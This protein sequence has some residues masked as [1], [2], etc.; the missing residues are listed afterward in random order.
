MERYGTMSLA[1]ETNAGIIPEPAMTSSWKLAKPK[2]WPMLGGWLVSKEKQIHM[3]A[4]PQ[5][6]KA[7]LRGVAV[8]VGKT[9]TTDT[10]IADRMVCTLE[11]QGMR[12]TMMNERFRQ[13]NSPPGCWKRIQRESSLNNHPVESAS[14]VEIEIEAKLLKVECSNID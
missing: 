3:V 2:G 13:Y 14:A 12:L 5:G 7:V 10:L 8:G 11:I 1:M 6:D 9:Q 4:G